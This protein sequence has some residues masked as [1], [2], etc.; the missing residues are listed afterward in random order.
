[1]IHPGVV[2]GQDV[3][4][5]NIP[6]TLDKIIVGDGAMIGAGAKIIAKDCLRIG[7]QARIG[8]NA[9]VLMDIP[10]GGVAVGIP[11]RVIH[12]NSLNE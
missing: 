1:M 6:A 5:G 4:P 8:A 2:L 3:L 9:V 11:A 7:R 12:I 10:D